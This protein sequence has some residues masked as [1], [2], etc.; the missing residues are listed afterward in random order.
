MD[1]RHGDNPVPFP[2]MH[3]DRGNVA[4]SADRPSKVMLPPDMVA[5]LKRGGFWYES[6]TDTVLRYL[7]QALDDWGPQ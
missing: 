5:R 7:G 6:L 3:T 1:Y 4:T 2:D